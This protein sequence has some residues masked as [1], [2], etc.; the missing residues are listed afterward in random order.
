MMTQLNAQSRAPPDGPSTEGRAIFATDRRSHIR[1]P[2]SGP[3]FPLS[4]AVV[5]VASEGCASAAFARWSSHP[6]SFAVASCT[7]VVA[8][9]AAAALHRPT[10]DRRWLHLGLDRVQLTTRA[11]ITPGI[12]ADPGPAQPPVMV[13]AV[14]STVLSAL[15]RTS[16]AALRSTPLPG[17]FL[18][19]GQGW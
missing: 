4:G 18:R 11:A 9:S 2:G 8:T 14:S 6:R 13:S 7:R 3:N 12:S 10:L 16:L 5:V 19:A 17:A 15:A 1:A